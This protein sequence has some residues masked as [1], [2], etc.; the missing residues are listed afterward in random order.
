MSSKG[1]KDRN[2]SKILPAFIQA[3]NNLNFHL[4]TDLPSFLYASEKILC[5]C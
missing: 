5:E 4:R 3:I 2:T 1:S